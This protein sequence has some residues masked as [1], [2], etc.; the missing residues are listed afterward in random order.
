MVTKKAKKD[1][2]HITNNDLRYCINSECDTYYACQ[3]GSDC[4]MN[5]YC[6]CGKI[7]KA[8]VP[9]NAN[10]SY[11]IAEKIVRANKLIRDFRFYCLDRF[12]SCLLRKNPDCFGVNVCR[13]YYGEETNGIT[14]DIGVS[15]KINSFVTQ[16]NKSKTVAHYR[17]LVEQ[18]LKDEY[19]Y[20][21]P[22]VSKKTWKYECIH[23]TN[24]KPGNDN[25]KSLNHK[26]VTQYTDE[27]ARK[28]EYLSCL[29]RKV[30]DNNFVLVDGYHRYI[31]ANKKSDTSMMVMWCK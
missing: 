21:L 27:Y 22:N 13:G 19:G 15:G 26:I 5:D 8:H 25:Y 31:A 14:M 10:N 30:D 29:C 12:I 7:I 23:I 20:L 16:L 28:N 18:V 4:C 11:H 24:I 2:N 6:R 9:E 1:F 17:S 3:D